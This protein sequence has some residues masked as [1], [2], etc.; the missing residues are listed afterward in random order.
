MAKKSRYAEKL[1]SGN[2]MYGPSPKIP[3]YPTFQAGSSFCH[4]GY[5]WWGEKRSKRVE[6]G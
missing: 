4:P 1:R 3:K 6:I 2:M 5:Y